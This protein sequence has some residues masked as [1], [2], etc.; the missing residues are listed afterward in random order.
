MRVLISQFRCPKCKTP[1]KHALIE[2]CPKCGIRFS[3]D[4]VSKRIPLLALFMLTSLIVTG[5]C[6]YTDKGINNLDSIIF[7]MI[8][9]SLV[10]STPIAFLY[11][12]NKNK[13]KR[14]KQYVGSSLIVELEKHLV[15]RDVDFEKKHIILP[16]LFISGIFII[17][18]LAAYDLSVRDFISFD[19]TFSIIILAFILLAGFGISGFYA[20]FKFRKKVNEFFKG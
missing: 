15:Y 20:V 17:M 9:V 8:F 18:F 1:I 2:Q 13:I 3:T 16:V 6:L 12:K 11:L 4:F 19:D 10:I 7:A 5:F 14:E